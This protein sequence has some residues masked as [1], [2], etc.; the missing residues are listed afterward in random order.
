VAAHAILGKKR[1]LPRLRLAFG[2]D[3]DALLPR[4][5]LAVIDLAEIEQMPV[6]SRRQPPGGSPRWTNCGALCRLCVER[7]I[8]KT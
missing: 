5:L 2:K 1:V 6:E 3:G 7:C 4:R 8:S